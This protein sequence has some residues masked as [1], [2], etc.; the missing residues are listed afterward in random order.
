MLHRDVRIPINGDTLSGTLSI[1]HGAH[2]LVLFVTGGGSCR[3]LA[4]NRLVATNFQSAGLATLMVDLLTPE[5]DLLDRDTGGYRNNVDLLS[6]RV[7]RVSSWLRTDHAVRA[8][9]IGLFGTHSGAAAALMAAVI[10]P[11]LIDAVVC[12]CG[13]PDM[14]G[15]D[16]Q[17]VEAA[18]L[19]IVSESD[20]WLVE[21][22]KEA[23][24][25]LHCEKRLAILPGEMYRY[26]HLR[27]LQRVGELSTEWFVHEFAALGTAH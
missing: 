14:A 16:L 7:S 27:A 9:H 6:L 2:A 23:F 20:S 5:E 1:P 12:F 24:E 15:K 3:N 13:R 18:T 4:E 8:M 22:N 21:R 10:R 11:S 25:S 19:L 26:Q 17:R